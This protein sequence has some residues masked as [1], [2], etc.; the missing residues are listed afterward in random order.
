MVGISYNEFRFKLKTEIRLG[1]SMVDQVIKNGLVVDPEKGT[2]THKNIGIK[3]GKIALI[4]TE[5]IISKEVWDAEGLVVSPGFIDIHSHVSGQDYA[6]L[7]SARQGI[8]TTVGGNCGAS[9]LDLCE[10]FTEQDEKGFLINQVSFIGHS[11][12]RRELGSGDPLSSASPKEIEIMERQVREALEAGACG[13]SLGLAYIPGSSEEE[14]F[15]LSQIVADAGKLIA[16]DTRLKSHDDLDSLR[17]VVEISRRTG[18]RTQVSHFVYQYG[19]GVLTEAL[20]I[21]DEARAE[22]IDIRLDSGMYTPWTSGIQA[23]LFSPESLKVSGLSLSDILIIT[24]PYKGQRVTE[25]LYQELRAQEE[26]TSVVVFGDGVEEEIYE[27]LRHPWAM[28]STDIGPYEPGEGHPQIAGSFPRYFSK[29]VRKRK[30]LS[31]IEAIRKATLLPAE[32]LNL[33]NKGRMVIGADADFVIFDPEV[34]QDGSDFLGIGEPDAPPLGIQ[35]V[36]VAGS[37][38]VVHNEDQGKKLGK[39]ERS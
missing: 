15:R 37:P 24:G 39:I 8:T 17:E 22:G 13:I 35:S 16:V 7:L 5:E 9:P 26:R 10:F 12:L 6:G 27:A 2:I 30:E 19:T 25:E 20:E 21:I 34:I 28:P 18:A 38:I 1:N 33:K 36:W 14:I 3:D 11:T 32:T 29:M 4:T 23:V 31:L